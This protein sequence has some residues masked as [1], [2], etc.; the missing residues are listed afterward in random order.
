MVPDPD[1][2]PV[3]AFDT[4]KLVEVGMVATIKVPLYPFGERPVITTG[5]FNA[6][7]WAADVG[8]VTTP[9][10]VVIPEPVMVAA[11]VR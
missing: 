4:V 7:P 11:K 10:L 6:N 2:D 9:P 5:C 1:P 8:Y 3:V